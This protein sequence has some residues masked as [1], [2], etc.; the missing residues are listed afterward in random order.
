MNVK[1]SLI[2]TEKKEVSTRKLIVQRTS[3]MILIFPTLTGPYLLEPAIEVFTLYDEEGEEYAERRGAHAT[4]SEV[5]HLLYLEV[6]AQIQKA[7]YAREKEAIDQRGSDRVEEVPEVGN[8][9]K[10]IYQFLRST[11]LMCL[12]PGTSTNGDY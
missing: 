9:R 10:Q 11:Y 4:S 2:L 12:L 5:K 8:E 1:Q 3:F 7:L 6:R